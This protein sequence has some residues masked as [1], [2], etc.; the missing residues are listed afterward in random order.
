MCG[1]TYLEFSISRLLSHPLPLLNLLT[2]SGGDV[3]PLSRSEHEVLGRIGVLPK[4]TTLQ[5]D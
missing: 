5:M 4:S 1:N 3:F 2:I